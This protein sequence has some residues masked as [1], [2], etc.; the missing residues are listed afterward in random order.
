MD[1]K[2]IVGIVTA[3]IVIAVSLIVGVNIMAQLQSTAPT[4]T[5]AT[6]NNTLQN[7][8]TSTAN[9]FNFATIIPIVVVAMAVVAIVIGFSRVGE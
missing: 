2:G 8:Y 7:V 3:L 5:D 9:A 1:T 4:V 6:L